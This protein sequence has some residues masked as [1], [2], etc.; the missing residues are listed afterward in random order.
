MTSPWNGS[1]SGGPA[2]AAPASAAPALELLL[3]GLALD[4]ELGHRARA[5]ALDADVLAA[6]RALAERA[7]L[8]LLEGGPRVF[9]QDV[10]TWYMGAGLTGEFA[11]SER[12][13][14]WDLNFVW[15]RNQ[16]NQIKNGGYNG[17][18]VWSPWRSSGF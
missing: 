14:F 5:Q 8:D 4:A 9:E 17:G 18:W 1:A 11:A 16:A 12:N 15:S 2:G 6:V 7:V 3:L 13:F 10:D